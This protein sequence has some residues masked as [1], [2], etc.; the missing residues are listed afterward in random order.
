MKISVYDILK[1]SQNAVFHEDGLAVFE[2]VRQVIEDHDKIEVSFENIKVCTTQFLNA[3]FGK[4]LLTY[5][6]DVIKNKVFPDS[7][8]SIHAFN[9]KF[10]LVWENFQEKNKS[11]IAEAYA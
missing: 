5:G 4:L 1:E 8:N 10:A 9:E 2:A 7:Y 11:I 3:S 6:E